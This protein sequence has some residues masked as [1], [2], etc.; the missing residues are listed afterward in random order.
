MRRGWDGTIL[1]G[2]FE[3]ATQRRLDGV[4]VDGIAATRHDVNAARDYNLL[5]EAGIRAARDGLRWHLIETAPGRYDWGS[6][7]A[8]FDAARR[9]GTMVVW[10]LCHWGWPE[11]LDIWKPE[12]VEAFAA[13]SHAAVREMRARGVPVGGVVPVNEISFWAWAGG[14]RPGFAP[15]GKGLGG[16]L[17]RQLIRAFLASSAAVRAAD[18]TIPVLTSEPLIVVKPRPRSSRRS[19]ARAAIKQASMYE[20]W[21]LLLGRIEPELGGHEQAFDLLGVNWYPQNQWL[22]H[23]RKLE[24][25]DPRRETLADLLTGLHGRYGRPIVITETGDEEPDCAD[26]LDRVTKEAHA[27]LDAG[28][29][30][31]GLCL[32]PVMDYSGWEN[33]RHCP[34]GLIALSP[35]FRERQIR[36]HVRDALRRMGQ[37]LRCS[38]P[39]MRD[40]GAV[41]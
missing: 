39:S 19:I 4:R 27:A 10:D 22:V 26:W 24:L 16:P 30:L 3:C 13:F 20:A 32:Y 41:A 33:E 7:A 35:S 21:D 9:T 8:M 1:L 40:L 37:R 6:A 38:E 28:V 11:H 2:G 36:P 29:P 14:H 5:A 31:A 34:C 23:G 15:H 17:K 12:F 25:D 18:P